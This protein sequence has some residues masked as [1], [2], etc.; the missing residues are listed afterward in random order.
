MIL[1][2]PRVLTFLSIW[3][4]SVSTI[5]CISLPDERRSD[6]KVIE[7]NKQSR[8]VWVDAPVNQLIV[9]ATEANV[10]ISKLKQRDLPIA[11][12]LTQTAAIETSYPP[13]RPSLESRMGEFPSITSFKT[14]K[15]ETEYSILLE[16]VARKIHAQVAQVEDIYYERIQINP[17]KKPPEFENLTE[18]FDVHVLVQL[19]PVESVKLQSVI[20]QVFSN[21]KASELRK[22]AKSLALPNPSKK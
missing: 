2:R 9:N 14:G 6:G 7:R 5:S 17:E 4:L 3:T 22:A 16:Q 20:H 13:W 19:H 8:P 12:K 11:I 15:H 10:H 1:N 18:Y 21:A